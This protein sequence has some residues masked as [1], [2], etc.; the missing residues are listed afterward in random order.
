MGRRAHER[1]GPMPTDWPF[2]DPENLAVFTLKRIVRGESPILRVAHDED[3]GGWQFLDGGE[4]AVED[5]SL[6]SLRKMTRLDSS[7]LELAALPV[8]W[9]AERAGP[10]EP[11]QRTP[12][13]TEEDRDKKLVSDIEQVGWHV[14]MIPEDDEGPS[15]A[16]SIGLFQTFGH[17]EII[18]CGLGLDLMH[19]MINI[20][21]DCQRDR[22]PKASVEAEEPAIILNGHSRPSHRRL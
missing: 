19:Q 15:F 9:I 5:A 13:V 3:D 4:V 20:L 8:G 18:I 21:R 1:G 16:Y 12:A 14:V 7:I 17:P 6:V 10:G 22:T 11:W 2:T